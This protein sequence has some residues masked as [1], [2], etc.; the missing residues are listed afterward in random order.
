MFADTKRLLE[1]ARRQGY[2]VGHFNI[3][4]MEIVQGIV[5]AA[6]NLK[7]PV[8]LST[9]EGALKYAGM[10]FLYELAKTAASL[11]TVPIVLHLDHGKDLTIIKQAIQIGYSSVMFDGSHLPFE[12]NV[13][14]TRKVVKM[15]HKQGV[16]VEAELG[17]IGGA[18]DTVHSRTIVYTDPLKAQEFV[19]R[20]GCDFLAVA[21]GT[22]H[23]AYKFKGKAFLNIDLLKEIA[24]K[25]S[26]PLVLHGASGVP[27][28]IV[29]MA[30]KFGAKL[31]DVQG[32]PDAE[33]RKAV[34]NGICKVNTDTDLRIA[35]DAAVR[36]FVMKNPSDFDPR[37]VLGPARDSITKVVEHRIKVLG[38]GIKHTKG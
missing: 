9:S 12:K 17:T 8:I 14:M 16:S 7:S 2:A 3:N 32:V 34:H 30:K 33:I 35:F 22:S 1:K 28:N 15:A 20:T 11:S 6:E 23:G 21:I 24:M 10:N 4:N 36:G 18:E 31:K 13:T 26:V 19:R 25:V 38:S 29:S 37:H 27:H 5:Q